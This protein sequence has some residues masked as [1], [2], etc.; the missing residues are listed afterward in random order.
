[1][2]KT[3]GIIY[4]NIHTKY[5]EYLLADLAHRPNQS[6]QSEVVFD[7]GI[8]DVMITACVQNS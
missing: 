2:G 5:V 7:V 4:G 8:V 3:A 1:M 6:M